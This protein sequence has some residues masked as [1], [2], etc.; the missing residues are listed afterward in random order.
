MLQCYC[1]YKFIERMSFVEELTKNNENLNT[2]EDEV[3]EYEDVHRLPLGA[4]IG[5]G[6]AFGVAA[7]FS[8]GNILINQMFGDMAATGFA[9][10]M[11]F[12]VVVGS[13]GG[14]TLGLINKAKAK[15]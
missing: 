14:L 12:C 6:F 15:K 5:I 10:G 8:V 9:I 7:G 4:F 11:A 2:E 1:K 3:I 13:L